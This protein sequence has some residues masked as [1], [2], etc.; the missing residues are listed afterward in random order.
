MPAQSRR[1]VRKAPTA[2]SLAAL[3]TA[4][5]VAEAA[6]AERARST[7]GK[8]CESRGS[9]SQ[10]TGSSQVLGATSPDRSARAGQ[11]RPRAMGRRISG[12]EAWARVA[13]SM[14]S[15]ME[16]MTDCGWTTT[17]ISAGSMSNSRCA[18]MSSSPLLIRVEE[19]T[20]TTGP[21]A[22]VGWARA[23]SA[24]TPVSSARL[25]PRKGPPEAVRMRRRTSVRPV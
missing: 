18:S 5:W 1:P 21:M 4:G 14:N 17:T 11:V 19:L 7:A 6:T 20:V 22:Q 10:E 24:V 23:C 9:K 8:V 25:R 3:R 15:T 13:P 12:G 16:W 2:C